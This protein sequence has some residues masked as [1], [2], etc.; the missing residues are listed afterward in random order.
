MSQ[1]K[2]GWDVFMFDKAHN[3]SDRSLPDEVKKLSGDA[4]VDTAENGMTWVSLLD[5]GE[6]N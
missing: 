2:D 4:K 6:E 5:L 3:W 1:V